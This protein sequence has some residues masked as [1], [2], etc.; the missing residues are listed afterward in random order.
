[1]NWL[2]ITIIAVIALMSLIG[3]RRGFLRKILGLAGIVAGVL[4]A[5]KLYPVTAPL[6]ISLFKVSNATAYILSFLLIVMIV[7]S[8]SIWLARYAS[9]IKGISLINRIFGAVLGFIQGLIL[10]SLFV[11]NL[12]IIITQL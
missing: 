5:V 10:T 3:F 1:M 4:L 2:D 6:F 8:I 7:Y 9:D 11:N 12:A